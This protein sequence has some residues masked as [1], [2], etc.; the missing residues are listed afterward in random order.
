MSRYGFVWGEG[1][2]GETKGKETNMFLLLLPEA[3]ATRL[4]GNLLSGMVSVIQRPLSGVAP[5]EDA[6]LFAKSL[7]L[8]RL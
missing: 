3:E 2:G 6:L 7:L 4:I 1:G 5:V 8:G